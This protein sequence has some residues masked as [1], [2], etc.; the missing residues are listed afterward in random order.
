MS[1]SLPSPF[2]TPRLYSAQFLPDSQHTNWNKWS[3]G[4]CWQDEVAKAW[5]VTRDA[6][7]I[8]SQHN[9]GSMASFRSSAAKLRCIKRLKYTI[10]SRFSSSNSADTNSSFFKLHADDKAK[11]RVLNYYF[12][13][14]ITL[15]QEFLLAQGAPNCVFLF[16]FFFVLIQFVSQTRLILKDFTYF[17]KNYAQITL[18]EV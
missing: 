13:C 9:L 11:V 17:L 4:Q 2:L 18:F 5:R 14:T 3:V 10:A 16:F 12:W 1:Y 6:C 8:I 15:T 7:M